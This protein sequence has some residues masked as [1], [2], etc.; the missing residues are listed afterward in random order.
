ML[1]RRWLAL[2]IILLALFLSSCQL[3]QGGQWESL[4]PEQGGIVLSITTDPFHSHL[5]YVGTSTGVVY[6]ASADTGP[7]LVPGVGI[8]HNALVTSLLADPEHE[9]TIYAGTSDGLYVST[10][11]SVTWHARGTGFP[12]GAII[13]AL[14]YDVKNKVYFAG[15]DTD[16]VFS[17]HDQGNTWLVANTG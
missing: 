6:A 13:V 4:G 7:N 8:P 2:P 16:G 12:S 1:T 14:A 3:V 17:S 5:V 10:N 15:T 11:R 9:G